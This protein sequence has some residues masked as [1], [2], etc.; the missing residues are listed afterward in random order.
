MSNLLWTDTSIKFKQ[1]CPGHTKGQ[2]SI[3]MLALSFCPDSRGSSNSHGLQCLGGVFL[4]QMSCSGACAWWT[5]LLT[6][7]PATEGHGVTA[8]K[9]MWL[10]S[11]HRP[12]LLVDAW[13]HHASRHLGHFVVMS[14]AT[15]V[16]IKQVA[17]TLIAHRPVSARKHGSRR[18]W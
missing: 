15:I 5:I 18:K 4:T 13:T 1:K 11:L 2:Q 7:L 3:Y 16:E 12:F 9:W 17:P 8:Q 6:P 10:S 14:L